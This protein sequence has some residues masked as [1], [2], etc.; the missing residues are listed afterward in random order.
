MGAATIGLL[1]LALVLAVAF[2]WL[3]MRAGKQV[4]ALRD[5]A[6]RGRQALEAEQRRSQALLRLSLGIPGEAELDDLLQRSLTTLAESTGADRAALQLVIPGGERLLCRASITAGEERTPVVKPSAL[7]QDEG[8]AGWVIQHREP[9]LIPDLGL[10]ERWVSLASE[11][12]A[13]RSALAVPVCLG[14][15]PLGALVLLSRR[16]GAFAAV[17]VPLAVAAAKLIAAALSAAERDR[18]ARAGREQM[19]ALQAAGQAEARKASVILEAIEDGALV[20]DASHQVVFYN[21]AAERLLGLPRETALGR[22]AAELIGL[23][24]PSGSSWAEAVQAWSQD[25]HAASSSIPLRERLTLEGGRL[26]AVTCMPV[27]LEGRFLG[28]VSVFH[29]MAPEVELNRLKSDF[30]STVSH[31]LRTPMTSI[32]GYVQLLLLETAGALND[33]QRSFLE[34]VK[35]NVDRLGQL[36]N[37]LLDLSRLEAGRVSLNIQEVDLAALLAEVAERARQRSQ[38]EGKAMEVRCVAEGALVLRGDPD[39][40]RQVLTILVD[41]A[42]SFTPAG[43]EI[44]LTAR[45]RDGGVEV[46]VA[47]NGMGIPPSEQPMVFERFFR[48]EQ[49]LAL[50][51]AGTGLGLPI[52]A[53]LV[54][55][56]GGRV[57][58]QSEG[59][60]GRG[61][62]VTISLPHEPDV[63][64]Q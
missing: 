58:L 46:E 20:T 41:N 33:D 23:F 7:R 44:R 54:G 25:P 60:P 27:S 9:A 38:D 32:R 56:H 12:D 63:P 39:R 57:R 5:Q 1:G 10:D 53:R 49:A 21:A 59:V 15:Q 2:A 43:G 34:V 42:F 30:V 14:G 17:H 55:L 40:L 52:A 35:S 37:D 4:A 61:T 47:D 6:E 45:S 64:P 13:S 24:G 22:P 3:T 19:E 62:A 16:P 36:V 11:A 31:E 51:V 8:L 26:I 29:D 48:G 28:T 18:T 50:G